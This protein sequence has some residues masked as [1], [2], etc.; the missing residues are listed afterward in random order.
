[1]N[2]LGGHRLLPMSC[3]DERNGQTAA[4]MTWKKRVVSYLVLFT[5]AVLY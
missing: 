4:F 5:I 3:G 1:M 2:A